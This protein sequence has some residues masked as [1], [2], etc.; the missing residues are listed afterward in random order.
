MKNYYAV[1]WDDNSIALEKRYVYE[2]DNYGEAKDLAFKHAIN[3]ED[4]GYAVTISLYTVDIIYK[5]R[6]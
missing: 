5:S 4:R 1:R 6:G 3:L 2:D